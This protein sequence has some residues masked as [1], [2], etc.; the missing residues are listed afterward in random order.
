MLRHNVL[1]LGRVDILSP[2]NDH[3]FDPV[4][5]VDES[6]LVHVA[7]IPSVHPAVDDCFGGLLGTVPITHHDHIATGADLTD[8]AARHLSIV[9]I[10]D[11][12]FDTKRR[13]AARAVASPRAPFAETLARVQKWWQSETAPTGRRLG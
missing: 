10:D 2:G 13:P 8:C 1:D 11:P 4:H 9:L 6:I 12:D 3:V 7:G 5:Y